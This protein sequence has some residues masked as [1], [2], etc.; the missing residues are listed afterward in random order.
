M[1]HGFHPAQCPAVPSTWFYPSFSHGVDVVAVVVVA[2]VDVA[3]VFAAGVVVVD[4]VENAD[5]FSSVRLWIRNDR[6]IPVDNGYSRGA[7]GRG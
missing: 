4:F 1:D 5:F 3:R 6:E 2:R 7:T